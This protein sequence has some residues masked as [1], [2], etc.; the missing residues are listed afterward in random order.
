MGLSEMEWLHKVE[1]SRIFKSF[2]LNQH[3]GLC[4]NMYSSP[5]AFA[6]FEFVLDDL[7]YRFLYCE[8]K[9]RVLKRKVYI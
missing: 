7:V 5:Q 2:N 3:I 6:S 1:S 8:K 9:K 4:A